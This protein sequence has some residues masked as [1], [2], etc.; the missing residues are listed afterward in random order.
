MVDVE[1]E[2]QGIPLLDFGNKVVIRG[3]LFT[4]DETEESWIAVLPQKQE[5]FMVGT[6]KPTLQ[7]WHDIFEQQ[8]YNFTKGELNGERVILRKTQRNIDGTISWAVFRRD[9][10]ACR[11]CG[12]D[13]VPLTVDHIITWET[14]GATH[15]DNLL[16]SCKKCNRTRGNMPYDE[17]LKTDYYQKK[18]QYLED[19]IIHK[20]A[21]II[22]QLSTLP[23]V[24]KMRK[25]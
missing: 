11:Y 21:S 2:V 18:M 25:R 23:R 4:N 14:G 7:E 9:D 19:D 22:S 5:G 13:H 1:K 16:S 20:N 12:I 10:Y 17:W 24:T 15:V 6:L 3:V 8:D